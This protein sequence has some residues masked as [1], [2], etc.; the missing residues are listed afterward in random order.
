L[1]VVFAALA[2]HRSDECSAPPVCGERMV[3]RPLDGV[4]QV[5]RSR[6]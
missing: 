6:P 2:A 5:L 4:S 1:A 3:T